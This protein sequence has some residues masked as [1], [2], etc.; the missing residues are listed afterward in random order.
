[1]DRKSL[2]LCHVLELLKDRFG[3]RSVM[4]EGGAGIISSFAFANLVDCIC[5]TIAPKAIGNKDGLA[6]FSDLPTMV[7]FQSGT[8]LVLGS[9]CILLAQWQHE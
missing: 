5:V 3:I 6:A 9:D 2:D 7:D 4:V 1:L 8:F